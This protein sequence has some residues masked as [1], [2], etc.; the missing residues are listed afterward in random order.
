MTDHLRQIRRLLR[1]R[2]GADLLHRWAKPLPDSSSPMDHFYTSILRVARIAP[3][4]GL[5]A[6][7]RLLESTENLDAIEVARL[8]RLH[9]HTLLSLGRASESAKRYER[10]WQ[11]FDRED[12]AEE[13]TRTA[14]GWIG[15]LAHCGDYRRM[16]ELIPVARDGIARSDHSTR[17]R[18]DVNVA[19][20]MYLTGR[21]DE[22]AR[23]YGKAAK[24]FQK[25][26]LRLDA[27]LAQANLGQVYLRLGRADSAQAEFTE[28]L[29]VIEGRGFQSAVLQVQF[30]LAAVLLL[31][32]S[33]EQALHTFQE[34]RNQLAQLG[35]KSTVAAIERELAQLLA[36]VGENEAALES[37]TAARDTY[38]ALG[39]VHSAALA[40]HQ[41]GRLLVDAGRLIDA[42][43]EL[44][45]TRAHFTEH[46]NRWALHRI[47]VSLA[48]LHLS[49][50]RPAEAQR[51]LRRAQ[52]QL[53]RSDRHGLGAQA[54]LLRARAMFDQGRLGWSRRL[55]EVAWRDAR[56]YPA[57]NQR[58]QI[59][60][61]LARTNSQAGKA[62]RAR[63][64]SQRA[65]TE[66]EAV[67]ERFGQSLAGQHLPMANRSLLQGVLAVQLRDKSSPAVKRTLEAV[68]KFRSHL[69][70]DSLLAAR[71]ETG[72]PEIET[73]LSQIREE[74]SLADSVPNRDR[75]NALRQQAADL[76]QRMRKATSGLTRIARRAG[77]PVGTTDWTGDMPT[78]FFEQT[79]DGWGAFV[80]EPGRAPRWVPL[81]RASD[82]LQG[83]W[84]SLQILFEAIAAAPRERRA[85]LMTR[86]LD[87]A[88]RALI[89]VREALWDPLELPRGRVRV[90][91][92][93]E[94][95]RIPF[96]AL[97]LVGE[98][99]PR[100]CVSRGPLSTSTGRRRASSAVLLGGTTAASARE[101]KN[102]QGHLGDMGL[103]VEASDERALLLESNDE[104]AVLHLSAHGSSNQ[105][106]WFLTGL[107][108]RDGWLGLEHLERKHLRGSLIF[109]GTCD[110]AATPAAGA[111]VDS[112]MTAGMVAGA[113]EMVLSLWKLDDAPASFFTDR[114][115]AQ[116]ATDRVAASAITVAMRETRKKF[117]HPFA[118]AP[119]IVV[120]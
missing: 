38:R 104:L 9:G 66:F 7:E 39:L 100:H 14:V 82:V 20:A 97:P 51:I 6:V 53:D 119:F 58:P 98:D 75:T 50:A 76:E 110:S 57:I 2:P 92:T 31:R 81:D 32:G 69:L 111:E 60:L 70:T 91:P 101:L 106:H 36:S 84:S 105:R 25:L 40:A 22:A 113:R 61:L 108:L 80:V 77:L 29:A 10:A 117:P 27:A 63:R 74:L 68:L 65:L 21:F 19:N 43:T 44:S 26:N 49:R 109:F 48:E 23:A 5:D 28:S 13:R 102:V 4:I 59:A 71:R 42:H 87:K 37:A 90:V 54:R 73:A 11:L 41:R 55:A 56:A 8:T 12:S 95:C 34:L 112:W 3:T 52:R 89:T 62:D 94:V 99:T 18:L 114:F 72:V 103:Q 35:D 17:V 78:V 33:W 16:R 46:G 116:W 30:G 64:W 88:T 96:E 120:A 1:L 47:D 115:Y 45:E 67:R 118:W 107:R 93:G 15:S 85:L 79:S 86:T 83:P 24:R